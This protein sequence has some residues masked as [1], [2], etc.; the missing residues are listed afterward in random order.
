MT[1]F[2]QLV[3]LVEAFGFSLSRINGSHHIFTHPNIPELVNLQN[4]NGKAVTYQI[5]QFQ[6][7]IEEYALTLVD[8]G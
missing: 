8:E 3:S 4:R 1:A 6:I 5:R 7:L 2:N